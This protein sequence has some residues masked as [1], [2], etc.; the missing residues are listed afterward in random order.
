M[1]GEPVTSCNIRVPVSSNPKYC[2]VSRFSKTDS[3]SR[4]RTKTWAGVAARSV[5]ETIGTVLQGNPG[6]HVHRARE[7]APRKAFYRG[8]ARFATRLKSGP[9]EKTPGPLSGSGP[10]K[11]LRS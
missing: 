6:T 9:A 10:K 3:R 5:N 4:K 11:L 1:F 8:L 2:S 7:D